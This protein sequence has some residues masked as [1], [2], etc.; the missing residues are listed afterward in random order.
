MRSELEDVWVSVLGHI[1][2]AVN[3]KQVAR[4]R[5]AYDIFEH[6]LEFSKYEKDVPSVIQK[7]CNK[8]S[9]QAPYIPIEDIEKLRL[10]EEEAMKILRKMPKLLTLKAAEYSKN[11]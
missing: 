1:Y 8:L 3:W 4:N 9:L 10:H 5:S 2:H 7:L 6:R 11:F